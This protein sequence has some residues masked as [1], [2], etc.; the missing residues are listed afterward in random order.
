MTPSRVV[1]FL[2]AGASV[3]AG[4]PDTFSF[5][6]EFEKAAPLYQVKEEAALALE[7]LRRWK[8]AQVDI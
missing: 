3:P 7:R 2:G 5:V 4:V 1:F 6:E 8:G